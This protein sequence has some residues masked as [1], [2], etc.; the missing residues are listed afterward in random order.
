V[1][2]GI[3]TIWTFGKIILL[4]AALARAL[5][6]ILLASRKTKQE[7]RKKYGDHRDARFFWFVA[8]T[9]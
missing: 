5:S 8:I 1:V 4:P 9:I 3:Q 6:F 7:E 2:F